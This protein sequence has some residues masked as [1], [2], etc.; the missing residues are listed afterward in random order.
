MSSIASSKESRRLCAVAAVRGD[1]ADVFDDAWDD[2]VD[3]LDRL[4]LDAFEDDF[5]DVATDWSLFFGMDS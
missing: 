4:D 1:W 3:C 2:L 5:E